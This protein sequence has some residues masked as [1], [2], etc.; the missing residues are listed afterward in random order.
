MYVKSIQSLKAYCIC[1]SLCLVLGLPS[2]SLSQS[3]RITKL[4]TS[5]LYI[6]DEPSDNGIGKFYMGRE[7]ARVMSL[8]GSSWLERKGRQV[9][10]PP[11][12]VLKNLK[13][14]SSDV[15]ADVGAGTGYYS[16]RLSG[17]V[18]KGNVLAV[19]IKNEFLEQ[20]AAKA[21]RHKADNV[22][23]IL[24]TSTDPRLPREGVD[25][26]LMV[27]A[28]HEFSHPYEMMVAMVTALKPHGL[29]YLVEYKGEEQS[30][31]IKALHKMTEAQ[32]LK[33]MEAVGLRW[34]E[35]RNFLPLQHFVVFEKVGKDKKF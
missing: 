7:I 30:I 9:S 21:L 16:L 5:R 2:Q 33:E 11:L 6:Y 17:Y 35:T 24:G 3:N 15:V 34:K 26:I 8:S 29:I 4:D 13:L 1:Y 10:E 23:T 14:K 19:D 28:Y 22:I 27:D 20:I 32:I 31:P 18:P 12:Q 25:V